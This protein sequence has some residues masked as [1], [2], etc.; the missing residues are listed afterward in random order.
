MPVVIRHFHE[1]TNL[2]RFTASSLMPSLWLLSSS[3]QSRI[4]Q[5][6]WVDLQLPDYHIRVIIPRLTPSTSTSSR[7]VLIE[8]S[9]P[10]F[11]ILDGGF[12][13]YNNMPT[14]R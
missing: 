14:T 1:S 5:L 6:N 7:D 3:C 11:V 10:N 9:L 4:R 12:M 2:S 8:T 13:G